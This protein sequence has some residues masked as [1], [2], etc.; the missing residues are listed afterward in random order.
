LFIWSINASV[1]GSPEIRRI[2]APIAKRFE[3]MAA[4]VGAPFP[5]AVPS[6]NHRL[7][8]ISLI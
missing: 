2:A 3:Q 5:V 6:I 1:V 8:D 4:V 7:S